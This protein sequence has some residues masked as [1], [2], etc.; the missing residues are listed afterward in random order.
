MLPNRR[1]NYRLAS[2]IPLCCNNTPANG[3]ITSRTK[4]QQADH[5]KACFL[6]KTA[7]PL[8]RNISMKEVLDNI[9]KL[10][11][12]KAFQL[13]IEQYR[14]PYICILKLVVALELIAVAVGLLYKI[15]S[16]H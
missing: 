15:N 3:Y 1:V 16:D 11:N 13:A 2:L 10:F 12:L 9:V 6:H 8:K 5:D 14:L 7:P 4:K